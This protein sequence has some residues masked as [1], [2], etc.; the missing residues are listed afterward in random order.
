MKKKLAIILAVFLI[1]GLIFVAMSFTGN[2]ISKYL[3]IK[4]SNVYIK[5]TYS[6]LEDLLVDVNYNFK[7]GRYDV[8]IR[9]SGS[10]DIDFLLDYDLFGKL[11]YDNYEERISNGFNTYIRLSGEYENQ[12]EEY[13]E[14]N[15]P[16]DLESLYINLDSESINLKDFSVDEAYNYNKM[17]NYKK[18]I[19]VT[20][21]ADK[22]ELSV[23]KVREIYD[24]IREF[25]EKNNINIDYYSI[26]LVK[27]KKEKDYKVF[28]E[29]IDLYKMPKDG[30][31]EEYIL[32]E[33]E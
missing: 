2:P 33:G 24:I 7:S 4:N 16:L 30:K 19:S 5:D 25:V 9:K 1:L 18:E 14:E 32:E 8:N 3:V 15:L 29:S 6:E 23:D 21:D 10:D 20:V 13:L 27:F 11:R 26:S 31:I 12:V 17:N 22:D 28:G